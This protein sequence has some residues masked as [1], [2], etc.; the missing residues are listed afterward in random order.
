MLFLNVVASGENVWVESDARWNMQGISRS[1]GTVQRV[2]WFYVRVWSPDLSEPNSTRYSVKVTDLRQPCQCFK[3]G[4]IL[5]T[6]TCTPMCQKLYY[7]IFV[8]QLCISWIH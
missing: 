7:L 2:S 5:I 1:L 8:S 3:L 6:R 4:F